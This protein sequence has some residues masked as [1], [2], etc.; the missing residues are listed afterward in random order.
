MFTL[1]ELKRL[2]KNLT[3]ANQAATVNDEAMSDLYDEL[4]DKTKTITGLRDQ[5]GKAASQMQQLEEKDMERSAAHARAEAAAQAE[6][7]KLQKVN[8]ALQQQLEDTIAAKER[9]ERGTSSDLGGAFDEEEEGM[10]LGDLQM[11]A[12]G[13]LGNMREIELES[14]VER[15]KGDIEALEQSSKS[16]QERLTAQLKSQTETA[17]VSSCIRVFDF[18]LAELGVSHGHGQGDV[19]LR[20]L[21]PWLLAWGTGGIGKCPRQNGRTGGEV[22]GKG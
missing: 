22:Q 4:T 6:A 20:K 17:A 19:V 7:H 13:G 9:L 11:G 8:A 10:G 15:L 2:R 12:D 3:K 16:N 5:L 18:G 14:E 1:A 21:F